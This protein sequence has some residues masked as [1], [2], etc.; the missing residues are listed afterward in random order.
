[1]KVSCKVASS[2]STE[3]ALAEL[4]LQF[5]QDPSRASAVFAFYGCRHDGDVIGDALRSHFPGAALIGGS[6]SGGVMD[7]SCVH[8]ADS[9]GVFTIE[10]SDGDYGAASAP[11]GDDPAAAAESALHAAL[12]DA[13]CVGELPALIWVYQAPGR[14]EAVL[15]GLRRVVGDRCPIVG[16]SSADDAVSGDWSQLGPTGR[17]V[18]SV[19]VTVL[20]PSTA[21]SYAFQGGYEPAGPTGRVTR[22]SASSSGR[23]ILEIDGEP[24]AQVYDRWTGNVIHDKLESGGSIL[25][26]TTM[27]PFAITTGQ[28]DGLDQYLLIHPEAVGP[29]GALNTFASV[30]EGAELLA[31]RGDA[32][33]LVE[34]AG[35]VMKQAVDRLDDAAPAGALMVYC[36]GCRMAVADRVHD[37]PEQ[38]RNAL[39]DAPLIGCFTFGEQGVLAGRNVHGNLMISSIVFAA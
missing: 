19:V 3:D 27:T 20:F 39:G 35:R 28:V 24:A 29:E 23:T 11:L 21:V 13:D 15:E 22:V 16:G 31:M 17:V 5:D 4:T 8:G 34:R 38:V 18:E 30:E 10:D 1:M 14:E 32:D 9:I 26:Q 37:V 33:Q 12:A 25:A 36:A 6:S 7:R 2:A